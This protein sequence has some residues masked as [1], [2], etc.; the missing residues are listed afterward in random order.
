MA[1]SQTSSELYDDDS[2]RVLRDFL[3]ELEPSKCIHDVGR[4]CPSQ[5]SEDVGIVGCPE[6]SSVQWVLG[7]DLLSIGSDSLFGSKRELTSPGFGDALKEHLGDL[8]SSVLGFEEEISQFWI[9]AVQ[10]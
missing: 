3:G 1:R 6:V 9:D 8:A 5:S 2:C 7:E 10:V 4:W